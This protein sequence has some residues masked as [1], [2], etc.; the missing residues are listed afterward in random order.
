MATY[1]WVGGS[2]TWD[3][4]TTT[5]WSLTSGGSGG[6]GVP[7]SADDVR[8]NTLSGTASD[9][10]SVVTGAVAKSVIYTGLVDFSGA[11]QE[12]VVYGAFRIQGPPPSGVFAVDS[13]VIRT[14]DSS[15]TIIAV[16]PLK[17]LTLAN[18]TDPIVQ[19]TV[20][21]SSN[22]TCDA[23]YGSSVSLALNFYTLTCDSFRVAGNPDGV[24]RAVSS[25]LIEIYPPSGTTAAF[26]CEWTGSLASFT[27]VSVSIINA[28]D[29]VTV[30]N[31]LTPSGSTSFSLTV[32]N[33]NVYSAT[34]SGGL[35][36]LTLESGAD[37][38]TRDFNLY[39]E[40]DVGAGCTLSN[41]SSSLYGVQI[42]K[43]T[44]T[45][46]VSRTIQVRSGGVWQGIG[47]RNYV[48]ASTDG[49]TIDGAIGTSAS[50]VSYF[51]P[52]N[53]IISSGSVHANLVVFETGNVFSGTA[54]TAYQ[55][56]SA[57]GTAAISGEYTINALTGSYFL[58]DG[59]ELATVNIFGSV[60]SYQ[61]FTCN[62]LT[63]VSVLGAGPTS[64]GAAP[65]YTI[66][67]LGDFVFDGLAAPDNIL[68]QS[69]PSGGPTGEFFLVK[70]SG[71]VNASFATITNCN[72]SGGA[73][74]NAYESN[75]CVD[76]GGN[77]GWNFYPPGGFFLFL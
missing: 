73:L 6:A 27:G 55:S 1:Y 65:G 39:G 18:W 38:T 31:A 43:K 32:S 54:I 63:L 11:G 48:A 53:A 46:N 62:D 49:I 56:V 14:L 26:N 64:F 44:G 76:G 35:D 4:S 57:T 50:P 51:W 67:V 5:N 9:T 68:L 3:A 25:G 70:S 20:T 16:V 52:G 23:F 13:V 10:I 36:S 72:A 34:L 58:T 29:P 15:A 66:T 28:V 47:L 8:V 7:T 75:G 22:V 37:F 69:T 30:V 60:A 61:D 42:Q 40:L 17:N 21:L 24:A 41:Y 12:L 33:S 59:A 19:T 71:T 2:G 77:T 74:F 45:P